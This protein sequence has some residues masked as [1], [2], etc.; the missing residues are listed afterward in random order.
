M[1]YNELFQ[2]YKI[3]KT[4]KWLLEAFTVSK[5]QLQLFFL[6]IAEWYSVKSNTYFI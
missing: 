2:K 5:K 6:A 4:K 3:F 1:K